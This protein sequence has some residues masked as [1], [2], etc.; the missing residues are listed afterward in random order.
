MDAIDLPRALENVLDTG[1][2]GGPLEF[3]TT[4]DYGALRAIT[5]VAAPNATFCCVKCWAGKPDFRYPDHERQ[6]LRTLDSYDTKMK[7]LLRLLKRQEN[8]IYD[9]YHANNHAIGNGVI[10]AFYIWVGRHLPNKYMLGLQDIYTAHL[11]RCPYHPPLNESCGKKDWMPSN[12]LTKEILENDEFWCALKRLLPTTADNLTIK[13]KGQVLQDPL[14]RYL[15][16]MRELCIQIT[17]WAPRDVHLRDQKCKEAHELFHAIDLPKRRFGVIVHYFFE[18]YTP[19]LRYHKNLLSVSCE[20]GEHLHQP[21]TSIVARRPSRPR[22]KC[23]VGLREVMKKVR[24]GQALWRQGWST[25]AMWN[26]KHS[27]ATVKCKK[28]LKKSQCMWRANTHTHAHAHTH[29]GYVLPTLCSLCSCSLLNL[30]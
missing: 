6:P 20:G 30:H 17:S 10:H 2:N 1:W 14:Q 9:P 7:W 24:L 15:D 23:P 8:L 4:L 27:N 13:Y 26:T 3:C 18:H 29:I 11:S 16:L 28:A 5:N 21:H 22:Y 19:H 25:L 12:S